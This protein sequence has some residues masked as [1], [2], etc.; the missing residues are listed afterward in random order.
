MLEDVGLLGRRRQQR[1]RRHQPREV[2]GT[3]RLRRMPLGGGHDAP[4][5]AQP[6]RTV[7]HQGE[8]VAG[9]ETDQRGQ[10]PRG[11]AGAPAVEDED[12]P[13]E[14]LAQGRI[15][16]A[17]LVLDG[18]QR[19]PRHDGRREESGAGAV[20][21]ALGVVDLDAPHAGAWRTALE[22]ETAQIQGVQL[23]HG[24][25]DPRLHLPR[26]IAPRAGGDEPNRAV[27]LTFK[28]HRLARHGQAAGDL[29]TEGHPVDEA[30]Q[31]TAQERIELV[32]SVVAHL[33]AE[34]AGTDAHA[35]FCHANIS[36]NDGDVVSRRARVVRRSRTSLLRIARW[37]ALDE[38]TMQTS[39]R[40]RVTAV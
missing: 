22:D 16:Q 26:H 29:G 30:P 3:H 40:A 33:L 31:R 34:Q 4:E 37:M 20:R 21:H 15:V 2:V 17:P 25:F 7:A 9:M 23:R 38:P 28:V 36:R 8:F 10:R 5:F 19:V 18:Q 35:D 32:L 39:L 24:V 6:R 12:P 14:V 1:Q 11:L 13:D 27:R